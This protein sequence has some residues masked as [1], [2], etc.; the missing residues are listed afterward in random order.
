MFPH[1]HQNLSDAQLAQLEKELE[2]LSSHFEKII[3]EIERDYHHC[4]TM[5]SELS[6]LRGR[7]PEMHNGKWAEWQ[8]EINGC[9]KDGSVFFC[10]YCMEDLPKS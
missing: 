2:S 7:H 9:P 8:W 1:Q 10:I 5:P 6:I 4:E 3:S